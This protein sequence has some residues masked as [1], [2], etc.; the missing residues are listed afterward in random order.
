MKSRLILA[1]AFWLLWLPLSLRSQEEQEAAAPAA[2]AEEREAFDEEKFIGEFR[3]LIGQGQFD[4]ANTRLKDALEKNPDSE[5]LRNLHAMA[6]SYLRRA[7]RNEDAFE[8]L[9]AFTD[10]QLKGIGEGRVPADNFAQFLGMLTDMGA[11][12]GG[13]ERAFAILDEYAKKAEDLDAAKNEIA[14]AVETQRAL[15][16]AK[17]G[18]VDEAKALVDKQVEAANEAISKDPNSADGVLSMAAALKNRVQVESA[19]EGGDPNA[20]WT[21]LLEFLFAKAKA[22]ADSAP[23]MQQFAME[24]MSRAA[25]LARTNPDEAE[26]ILSRLESFNAESQAEGSE[27]AAEGEQAGDRLRTSLAPSIA[28][29]REHI[30]SSRKMLAL[31]G[32]PA[33]YPENADGWVNGEPLTSDN[34]KGKVVLLDFFAVWCGPC[35]ATFPHLKEWHDEF[36]DKG[37][38]IIGVTDY[39]QYGWDEAASRSK[40]EP[41]LAPEA[42]R[43]AM[44]HFV[45]HHDLRHPVAFVTDRQLQDFYLVRG[46]PHAVVIDRQGKVRLIR[47]GSGEANAADLKKAIEE[48]LNESPSA[49]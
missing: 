12:L 11:Q 20:A 13:S 18:R 15:Q 16:L 41:E 7:G 37:L 31:I 28:R 33:V 45:K 9:K 24:H 3:V 34:L 35:I 25:Q 5:E 2:T 40:Q 23:I 47:V 43:S 10:H 36:S 21:E 32:S 1:A 22:K 44:E 6:Y 29:L 48:S 38:Q 19:A 27:E 39:Y 46:I 30:E 14:A 4:E 8:H 49:E 42:E 17:A 26:A